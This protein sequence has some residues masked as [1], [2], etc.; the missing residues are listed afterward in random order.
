[1][2]FWTQ[3]LRNEAGIVLNECRCRIVICRQVNIDLIFSPFLFVIFSNTFFGNKTQIKKCNTVFIYRLNVNSFLSACSKHV[4]F[5]MCGSGLGKFI[6]MIKA[7]APD[8]KCIKL[9]KGCSFCLF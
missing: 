2:L 3:Q 5:F 4:F 1:M 7:V 6:M 8:M 9:L